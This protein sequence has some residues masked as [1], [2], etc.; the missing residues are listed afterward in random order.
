MMNSSV[1][2]LQ[3]VFVFSSAFFV[4][5]SNF[6]VIFNLNS[7]TKV[8]AQTNQNSIR[9]ALPMTIN[10][11]EGY[12][13]LVVPDQQ[14]T[15]SAY[16]GTLRIYDVHIAKM[17][18]VTYQDCQEF[19]EGGNRQWSYYA[20]NG[21]INMGT[22][23]LPCKLVNYVVSQFGLTGSQTT[24]IVVGQ[25]EAG[26]PR[27]KQVS[28]PNLNLTTDQRQKVWVEFTKAFKPMSQ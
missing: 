2:L 8:N 17:F 13:E 7:S 18:E 6:S 28:I 21:S 27:L 24:S 25:E 15:K 5:L 16:G 11:S 10:F 4:G 26:K 3:K 1:S 19:G 23:D 22:F 14:T 9:S 12:Y 20:G